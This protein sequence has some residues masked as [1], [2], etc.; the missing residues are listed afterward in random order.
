MTVVNLGMGRLMGLSSDSKPTTYPAGTIFIETDTGSQYQYISSVWVKTVENRGVPTHPGIKKTGSWFGDAL[1]T[2]AQNG[3][4]GT[5]N[6]PWTYINV[7]SN[8]LT[9]IVRNTISGINGGSAMR[10]VNA[11]ATSQHGFRTTGGSGTSFMERD[12]NPRVD[13]KLKL[14]QTVTERVGV[15]FIGATATPAT[16]TEP[17]ANLHA[18]LFWLDTSVD[19]NWHIL[20]NNGAATSDITTIANVATADT[21]AHV[22]SLRADNANTKFQYYYGGA[23]DGPPTASSTWVDINTKIPSATNT[24]NIYFWTESIGAVT[25]TFDWYWIYHEQDP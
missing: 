13:F 11:V 20:Q 15:G 17:A 14:G 3:A 23:V 1:P 5:L 24:L 18:V 6:V 9:G 16:G 10:M 2:A 25:P 19:A 4:S 8:T 21:N 12:Y 7:G 22:F